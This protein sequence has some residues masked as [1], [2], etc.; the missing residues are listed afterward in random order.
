[1]NRLSTVA[2]RDRRMLSF[3]VIALGYLVMAQALIQFLLARNVERR[4]DFAI[5]GGAIGICLVLLGSAALLAESAHRHLQAEEQAVLELA[6]RVRQTLTR[7]DPAGAGLER[8]PD[9]VVCTE[10][11]FH[12]ADCLL[13]EHADDLVERPA[14]KAQAAQLSACRLCLGGMI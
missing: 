13:V 14:A 7:P 5:S 2:R 3:A 11:S 10:Y 12:R 9:V 1:M 6:L 8:M 4:M